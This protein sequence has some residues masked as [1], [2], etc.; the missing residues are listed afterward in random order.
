MRQIKLRA[1]DKYR[2][3]KMYDVREIQFKDGEV[4]K[5]IVSAPGTDNS[6]VGVVIFA[7]DLELMQYTGLKD[8]NGKEVYEGD[9]LDFA[10]LKPL[11]VVW[12]G[13][14]FK[15][16]LNPYTKSDPI[17]LTQEGF[18]AFAEVIGNVYSNPELLKYVK[19]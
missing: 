17:T 8:K 1:W 12:E 4:R 18:L 2:P 13:V 14:G 16:Y 5:V 10:G 3:S 6:K 7:K 11:V 15:T 9:I 19:F